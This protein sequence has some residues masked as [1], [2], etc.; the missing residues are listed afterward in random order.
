MLKNTACTVEVDV[1]D[2]ST[3]TPKTG[4]GTS[5][6]TLY[7]RL[8]GGSLTAI[9]DT[10]SAELN[11]TNAPGTYS[12][13]LQAAETNGHQVTITGKSATANC[14]VV[15]QT[16]V[17]E[18]SL[19]SSGLDAVLIESG[20]SATASLVDDAASQ[21][22]SINARQAM[23]LWTSALAGIL[24]GATGTTV[25]IKAGGKTTSRIVATVDADGNRSALTLTVP[26]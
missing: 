4:L 13:S 7:Y 22:T 15:R 18:S 16:F 1:Y 9:N 12:F 20:I 14:Y 8:D 2:A 19:A 5:D 23:A 24:S 25:T 21:L 17:T 3:G 10:T 11:S 6:I 26:T